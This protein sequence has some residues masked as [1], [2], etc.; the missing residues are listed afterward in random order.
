MIVPLGRR[1]MRLSTQMI[2]SFMQDGAVIPSARCLHGWPPDALIVDCR[3]D[4][5]RT[6]VELVIESA[7]WIAL[8]PEADDI[9]TP[10]FI[11]PP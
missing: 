6:Y 3:I 7:A 4:E 11:S 10:E 1:R 9:I 5:L 2:E 8:P